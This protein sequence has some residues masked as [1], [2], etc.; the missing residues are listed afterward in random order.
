[1]YKVS[2]IQIFT[3]VRVY[4]RIESLVRVQMSNTN[5]KGY[6]VVSFNFQ[7]FLYESIEDPIKSK[8]IKY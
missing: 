4:S 1:M 2:F 3:Y 7:K 5:E 6:R 8:C